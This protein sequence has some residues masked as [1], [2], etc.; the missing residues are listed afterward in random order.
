VDPTDP[1][2]DETQ[3]AATPSASGAR[4]DAPEVVGGRYQI[5][6][7]IGAGGMGTVYRARDVELDEVVALKMLRR[8]LVDEPDMLERFR[9]EVKLARRVTHQNV[10]RTFDIAEHAGEKFLTMEYVD[11]QSLA[12]LRDAGALS[13]ERVV[14]IAEQVCA[15]L[16]A[17]HAAGVV[18]RD[19]KPDNVLIAKDGRAVITDFGIASAWE[20]GSSART[21]G[22]GM[23]IGTPA[24]MAPEQVEEAEVIDARADLYALGVMLYELLTG[25]QPWRGSS[26]MN[27]AVA[28]LTQPPPD[29]RA[30]SPELPDA[31]AEIIL[32]LMARRAADRY[33]DAESV[34]AALGGVTRSTRPAAPLPSPPRAVDPGGKSVAVLPWRNQGAPEDDYLADALTDDLI[35]SL[36]MTRGLRVRARGGVARYRGVEREPR[37]IG[38]ELGVEV[39]VEGAVRRVG[40]ALRIT[41]RVISVADGF[42]IWAQRFERPMADALLVIDEEAAAIARALT[43]ERSA[44]VRDAPLDPEALDL[45]LR[46]RQLGTR[47]SRALLPQVT[48]LLEAALARAPDHPTLLASYARVC[49]ATWFFGGSADV[50]RRAAERAVAAG[51]DVAEA[52]VALATARLHGNDPTGAVVEVKHALALAPSLADAHEILGNIAVEVGRLDDGMRQLKFALALDPSLAI[53]RAALGRALALRAQWQ[54]AETLLRGEDESPIVHGTLMRLA[55]W[56]GGATVE[57][58]AHA[59]SPTDPRLIWNSVAVAEVL[60]TRRLDGPGMAELDRDIALPDQ[61]R[62]RKAFQNQMKVELACYV[63]EHERAMSALAAAVDAGLIDLAWLDCCPLLAPLRADPR[64][65]EARARVAERILPV[66]AAFES[67]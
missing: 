64:F 46:A 8:H 49:V 67:R 30:L 61:A 56:Q 37:E 31:L 21:V 54:E 35:D 14:E 9:R 28:R 24:Y 33:P 13:V 39:I 48:A 65:V 1:V 40:S 11:G 22:R 19:L 59:L 25:R 27:V 43:A 55:L 4:V 41:A 45:Y 42:Q 32:R 34:V 18:H 3:L 36:S 38:Q 2:N 29:P 17:A 23:P 66:Q 60:R 16:H 20:L 44:T 10:A 12:Q 57:A 53:A 50:A 52:H 7:L 58:F 63:G 51:P 62:R 6:G 47:R 15:G 26:V 5:L